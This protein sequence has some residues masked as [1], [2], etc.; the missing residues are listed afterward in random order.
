MPIQRE[1]SGK[2]KFPEHILMVLCVFLLAAADCFAEQSSSKPEQNAAGATVA[3]SNQDRP[4][5]ALGSALA[6]A[7]S[8][9]QAEFAR[10]LTV[11]NRESFSRMTAAARV[12][13][14]KRFVLLGEPGKATVSANPSGR[15][16]VRC[17]TPGA[18]TEM[19]IGGADVR[20]NVAFLPRS[21]EHTSELQS[22]VHL[23]CR[24]LL[25]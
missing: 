21:E 9:N 3:A 4:D 1:M 24:L 7:C 5:G 25:E 22:P 6:A 17:E 10:F 11:R 12:A 16:M 14:M 8:Q 15:P 23:V 20:D 13:L 2:L 18:T 19:Q